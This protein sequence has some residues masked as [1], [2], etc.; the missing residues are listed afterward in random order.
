M[1]SVCKGQL[2]D[3]VISA[4]RLV[5]TGSESCNIVSRH[6]VPPPD[7]RAA[8]R[9]TTG[10][11]RTVT[12]HRTTAPDRCTTAPTCC[13]IALYHHSTTVAALR[14]TVYS[15]T[16]LH[17]RGTSSPQRPNATLPHRHTAAR[18]TAKAPPDTPPQHH[19]TVTR[20]SL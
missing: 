12:L 18:H 19:R 17:R 20:L 11:H 8:P 6:T 16:P 5:V 9:R 1:R 14:R 10:P 13:I 2:G 4:Q 15:A 7:H 3:V